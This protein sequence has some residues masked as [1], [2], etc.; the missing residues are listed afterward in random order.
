MNILYRLGIMTI[1]ALKMAFIA[2]TLRI[3]F[4]KRSHPEG[5][6][7]VPLEVLERRN[8]RILA[9]S[10][11]GMFCLLIILFRPG[12]GKEVIH[13]G[14]HEQLIFFVLGIVGLL[15]LNWHLI[16]EGST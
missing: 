5:A 4:Y 10:E 15:H 14:R 8:A 9:L 12:Q 13:I 1:I 16:I 2:S 7:A 11:C 6:F 3:F